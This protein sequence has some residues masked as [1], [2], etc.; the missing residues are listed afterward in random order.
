[1]FDLQDPR[2]GLVNLIWRALGV[3]QKLG[4]ADVFNNGKVLILSGDTT[5]GRRCHKGRVL[6]DWG[7]VFSFGQLLREGRDFQDIVAVD[8][9][10]FRG[11]LNTTEWDLSRLGDDGLRHAQGRDGGVQGGVV[12][13]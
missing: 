5:F 11:G 1:M 7:L 8:I 12:T 6:V 9:Y 13:I 2:G 10:D 4:R 3:R